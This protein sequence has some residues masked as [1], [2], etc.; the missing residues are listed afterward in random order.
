MPCL[1]AMANFELCRIESLTDDPLAASLNPLTERSVIAGASPVRKIQ[2]GSLR[3]FVA[4]RFNAAGVSRRGSTLMETKR[5][6]A[7]L[8]ILEV[9]RRMVEVIM[10]H[11]P[12]QLVK[13]KS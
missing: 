3:T 2:R 9:I 10:G 1:S 4:Y 12:A 6:G 13:M 8:S 11:V 7:S 5:T